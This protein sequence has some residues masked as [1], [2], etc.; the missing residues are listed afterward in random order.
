MPMLAISDY[1][2]RL[3]VIPWV[4]SKLGTFAVIPCNRKRRKKQLTKSTG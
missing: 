1:L 3:E 2:F 4:L